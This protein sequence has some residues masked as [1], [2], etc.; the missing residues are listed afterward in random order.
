MNDGTEGAKPVAVASMEGLGRT[1]I[2]ALTL[3]TAGAR[4]R[5]VLTGWWGEWFQFGLLNGLLLALVWLGVLYLLG[6]LVFVIFFQP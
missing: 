4:L 6:L 5:A 2:F 1:S 3:R